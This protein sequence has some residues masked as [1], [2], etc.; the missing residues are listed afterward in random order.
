MS[1]AKFVQRHKL[2]IVLSYSVGGC[3]RFFSHPTIWCEW[4]DWPWNYFDWSAVFRDP[5]HWHSCVR[6]TLSCPNCTVFAW[7]I[8]IYYTVNNE[9]RII[10]RQS[11]AVS[12]VLRAWLMRQ[13]SCGAA[14]LLC[15]IMH[16]LYNALCWHYMVDTLSMKS[17]IKTEWVTKVLL[18]VALKSRCLI[19]E[20]FLHDL[21]YY[22]TDLRR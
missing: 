12:S 13:T 21:K 6:C 11:G 22:N 16:T 14:W 19:V 7:V 10:V 8:N 9:Q 4:M 20:M 5:I 17:V 2:M 3:E 15:S 18:G 1:V